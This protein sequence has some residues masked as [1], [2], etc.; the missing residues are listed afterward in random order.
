MD[1]HG[2]LDLADYGIDGLVNAHEWIIKYYGGNAVRA[3]ANVGLAMAK[4]VSPIAR[5]RVRTFIDYV[6]WNYG[7]GGE[8]KTTLVEYV[9][10]P[11]LGISG[12]NEYVVVKGPVKRDT[13]FRNLISLHR[14]PLILDEQDL[15]SLRENAG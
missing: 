11:L 5:R 15:R 1:P 12:V 10:T 6:V 8:G 2:E 4:V 13:Q 9:L 14:L 7:R 3:L